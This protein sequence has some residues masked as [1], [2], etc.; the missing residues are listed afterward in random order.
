MSLQLIG[1]RA[2]VDEDLVHPRHGE[3]FYRVVNQGA[4]DEREQSPRFF[5]GDRKI[6]IVEAV[7]NNNGLDNV[8]G[9]PFLVALFAPF[10]THVPS[11]RV[12]YLSGLEQRNHAY[13]WVYLP[14]Q[15]RGQWKRL[16]K[17][18]VVLYVSLTLP[19]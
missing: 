5:E 16:S 18:N 17:R 7:S 15:P 6:A 12:D 3:K 8:L 14:W 2:T 4:V 9:L 10:T 1:V 19:T 13:T 11:A